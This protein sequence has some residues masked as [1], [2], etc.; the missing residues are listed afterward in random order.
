MFH[1]RS[2]VVQRLLAQEGELWGAEGDWQVHHVRTLA[3]R[4]RPG[5]GEKPPWV[6]RMAARP[7]KT[8][9]VCRQCHEVIHQERPKRHESKA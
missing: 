7:R 8:L 3:D 4:D 5:Q 9:V 2:A 6:K 1:V